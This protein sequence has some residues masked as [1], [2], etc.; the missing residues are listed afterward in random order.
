MATLARSSDGTRWLRVIEDA[1][2]N[3]EHGYQLGALATLR[4][5]VQQ[6]RQRQ[7]AQPGVMPDG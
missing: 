1:L 7:A 3:L 5:A 2:W 4:N 6:E